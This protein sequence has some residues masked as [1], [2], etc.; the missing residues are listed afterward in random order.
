MAFVWHDILPPNLAV[1]QQAWERRRRI[2][3][4]VECGL[5]NKEMAKYMPCRPRMASVW[6]R[7]ALYWREHLS[8]KTS[9][10]EMYCSHSGDIAA[11]AAKLD[12]DLGWCKPAR[13]SRQGR[14]P[15]TPPRQ[16][17]FLNHG[18]NG[19]EIALL[20]VSDS[21]WPYPDKQLN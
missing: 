17:Y 5:T 11:M 8:H 7:A 14:L 18:E 1:R 6:R 2:A 20:W 15:E 10:L 21:T 4:M 9:P 12:P 3:R 13:G 16:E 19:P